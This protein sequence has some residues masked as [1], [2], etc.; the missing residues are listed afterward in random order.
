VDS[1]SG[2]EHPPLA[3]ESLSGPVSLLFVERGER[4]YV[5]PS[6]A[7]SAWSIEIVRAGSVRAQRPGGSSEVAAARLVTDAT[8]ARSIRA[9]FQEK[10]GQPAW[11][12]YF[13]ASHKIIELEFGPR[14]RPASYAEQVRNEF[15]A[16]AP[17]YQNA[18]DS[19]PFE[20]YLKR[21][22]LEYLRSLFFGRDPLLEIGPGT[23][24]ETLPLLAEGHRILALDLSEGMLAEL[25]QRAEALGVAERLS[26]RSGRLGALGAAL[27]DVPR[28]AYAGA[29]S[30][31]GAFNLEPDLGEVPAALGRVL[32]PG[33]PLC[34]GVLNP[35]GTV[36]LLYEGLIAGWT[37]VRGRLS[38]PIRARGN[39]Y[40]LDIY[41]SSAR[42][43]GRRFAPGFV[44]ESVRTISVLAP[45]FRSPR[46]LRGF[47]PRAFRRAEQLDRWLCRSSLANALGEWVLVTLRRTND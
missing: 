15:D 3:I 33:A 23:G 43:L 21:R 36:P 17:F 16:A 20:R 40:P 25:R 41:Y 28:G 34:V 45:P 8:V 32:A 13:A 26:T 37:G 31:F 6:G 22:S 47:S 27:A 42:S 4:L 9:A 30:T 35:F 2:P 14:A 1:A 19:N 38:N 7:R 46:L 12:R 18:V 29:F 39:R 44:L 11:D 24:F 10:Y 5:I